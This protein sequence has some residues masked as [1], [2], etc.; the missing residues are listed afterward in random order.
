MF[1]YYL[2]LLV[3]IFTLTYMLL[4]IHYGNKL[5][6]VNHLLELGQQALYI[7]LVILL[8]LKVKP[9]IVQLLTLVLS[10]LTMLVTGQSIQNFSTGPMHGN[11]VQSMV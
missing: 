2:I 10:L 11:L 4:R 3:Q 7:I 6:M 9:T 8:S 5:S 1:V